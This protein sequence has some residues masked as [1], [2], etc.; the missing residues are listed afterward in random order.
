MSLKL[1]AYVH[2]DNPAIKYNS[3]YD[4]ETKRF[5]CTKT[6]LDE[7]ATLLKNM[8]FQKMNLEVMEK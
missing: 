6:M 3:Y 1:Y 5:V 4:S 7:K 2:S 8:K